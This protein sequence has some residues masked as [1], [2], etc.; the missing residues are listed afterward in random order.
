MASKAIFVKDKEMNFKEFKKN[1]FSKAVALEKEN[2][3]IRGIFGK[4]VF[5][6]CKR[7]VFFVRGT[8]RI[9]A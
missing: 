1:N 9:T 5:F 2:L 3:K 4:Y 6:I 8:E 7:E